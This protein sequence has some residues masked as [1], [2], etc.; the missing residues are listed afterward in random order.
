ML[1]YIYICLISLQYIQKN[2]LGVCFEYV[3]LLFQQ[4]SLLGLDV[5]G[6]FVDRLSGRFKPYIGTGK[7]NITLL[8]PKNNRHLG[9]FPVP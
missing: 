1:A 2:Y 8:R 5:L 3:M 9:F 4:V 6:A 7:L